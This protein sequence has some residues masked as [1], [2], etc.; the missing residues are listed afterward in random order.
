MYLN[1]VRNPKTAEYKCENKKQKNKNTNIFGREYQTQLTKK[2][3]ELQPK[4]IFT[5]DTEMIEF[6]INNYPQS[7]LDNNSLDIGKM[8][9]FF[10]DDL[11]YQDEIEIICKNQ[12]N[13]ENSEKEKIEGMKKEHIDK[14]KNN[15][16]A[17]NKIK[18]L[19][20]ER[21]KNKQIVIDVKKNKEVSL[22]DSVCF[23]NKPNKAK[24]RTFYTNDQ[25]I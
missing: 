25:E 13:K 22:S 15:M 16:E 23:A 17:V 18:I 12:E 24:E 9:L 3:V 7:M 1:K 19:S 11:I 2:P 5:K 6:H 8:P 14:T 10:D 20:V 21:F 4:E